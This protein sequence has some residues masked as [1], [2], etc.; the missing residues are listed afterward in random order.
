MRKK[1]KSPEF[2]IL[3]CTVKEDVL[4]SST[5]DPINSQITPGSGNGDNMDDW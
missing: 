1:Y 3:K 4:T 5:E 2:E